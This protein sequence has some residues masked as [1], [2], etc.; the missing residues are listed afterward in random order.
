VLGWSDGGIEA[1]LLSMRHPAKV[2]K[3]AVMAANLS[4]SGMH[5]SA[6]ELL[7]SMLADIPA[8]RR[9]TP[10][11]RREVVLTEM[12]INE[13]NIQPS[14]LHNIT[15]PTLI[16]A[17][18]RDITSDEHTLEI[19]HSIPNSQLA[20]FPNSTHMAPYDNPTLVNTTVESFFRTPFVINDRINDL[21]KSFV[22]M[23]S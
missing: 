22:K 20:I 6:R 21:L 19:Y 11:G 5:P 7:T 17:G 14:A 15:A 4:P 23:R 9:A 8:A 18:D 16:M 3:I 10:E 2:K 1:L 12:A 13:P